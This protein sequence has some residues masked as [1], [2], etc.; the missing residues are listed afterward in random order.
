LELRYRRLVE[1]LLANV[2]AAT[3][4]TKH[5]TLLKQA[6]TLGGIIAAAGVSEADALA[7]LVANLPNTVEDWTSAAKTALD[8]LRR[9]MAEPYDLE[10]RP[11]SRT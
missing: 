6:R 9:G 8:G 5:T 10:D 4:G 11:W 2:R 1:K 7:W 3:E